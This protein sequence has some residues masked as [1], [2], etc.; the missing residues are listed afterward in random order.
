MRAAGVNGEV[1]VGFV[2]DLNGDVQEPVVIKSSRPE[3]EAAALAA[4]S[5][6]KFEPGQQGG[7]KTMTRL[8]VPIVFNL[9]DEVDAN[10]SETAKPPFQIVLPEENV[11]PPKT[12][13]PH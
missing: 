10:A 3:F 13:E 2:V 8:S 12:P 7:N 6:W 11:P 1:T 5:Q 4:V 9:N